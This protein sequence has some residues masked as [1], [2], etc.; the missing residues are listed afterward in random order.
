MHSASA[1][2]S[3]LSSSEVWA[4]VRVTLKLEKERIVG[5]GGRMRARLRSE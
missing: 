2:M 5:Y 3:L 1:E 4:A